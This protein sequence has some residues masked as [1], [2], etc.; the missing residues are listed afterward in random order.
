MDKWK[1]SDHDAVIRFLKSA[2]YINNK[3]TDLEFKG[4]DVKNLTNR[5]HKLKIIREMEAEFGINIWTPQAPTKTEMKDE[6][7]RLVRTVF[8]T[9]NLQRSRGIL[10]GLGQE[11][12]LQEFH[13]YQEGRNH[14]QHRLRDRTLGTE[15]LQKRKTYRLQHR[16][17][18]TFRDRDQR[19]PLL[20]WS[21]IGVRGWIIRFYLMKVAEI[22][23]V[24]TS[25]TLITAATKGYDII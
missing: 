22:R 21:G 12:N 11:C 9:N 14:H 5:Y 23:L 19:S 18:K 16:S 8:R 25:L 6:F 4:I 24:P 15:C 3:M 7:Y 13:Q 1:V 20:R 17:Q 2:D 10:R